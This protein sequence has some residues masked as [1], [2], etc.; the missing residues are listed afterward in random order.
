MPRLQECLWAGNAFQTRPLSKLQLHDRTCG[1]GTTLHRR[2]KRHTTPQVLSPSGHQ[3]RDEFLSVQPLWPQEV[4][5]ASGSAQLAALAAAVAARAA[6]AVL[7]AH[8]APGRMP[9]SWCGWTLLWLR[10]FCP[11]RKNNDYNLEWPNFTP[12]CNKLC[13]VMTFANCVKIG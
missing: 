1:K 5:F 3:L 4:G 7:A 8:A 9:Y 2:V 12:R 10:P 6:L 13:K 11:V